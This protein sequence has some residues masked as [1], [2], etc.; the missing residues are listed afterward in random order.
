MERYGRRTEKLIKCDDCCREEVV[1]EANSSRFA[2]LNRRY[3]GIPLSG[4]ALCY[5]LLFALCLLFPY[6]GDDWTWGSYIGIDRLSSGFAD[7]NGR[8]AGNVVVIA[9]TRNYFVRSLV[10]A[11][12]LLAVPVLVTKIVKGRLSIFI[13]SMA[14]VA[15]MP[16]AVRAQGIV[17]TSGFANYATS[18]I[19][20]L[21]YLYAFRK[22]F[23]GV[24]EIRGNWVVP[25]FAFG[26]VGCLFVENVSIY[27]LLVSFLM[28]MFARI[29]CGKWDWLQVAFFIGALVGCVLMFSNGNYGI[30]LSGGDDLRKVE[31]GSL[32]ISAASHYLSGLFNYLCLENGVL[33]IVL[34]V[35]VAFYYVKVAKFRVSNLERVIWIAVL[36]YCFAFAFFSFYLSA[37]SDS[38]TPDSGGVRRATA[39]L[40]Y[41]IALLL[42]VFLAARV[43]HTLFPVFV[44]LSVFALFLPF[45]LIEPVGPRNFLTIYVAYMVLASW[46]M[47]RGFE[48]VKLEGHSWCKVMR[49]ALV[50]GIA[51]IVLVLYS[52]WYVTYWEVFAIESERAAA[53]EKGL[54]QDAASITIAPQP[55]LNN[56]DSVDSPVWHGNPVDNTWWNTVYKLYYGIPESVVLKVEEAS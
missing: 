44:I 36:A 50:G 17:W 30:V 45:L 9:L 51:V 8:Y 33:N 19:C 49:T 7:Y 31:E 42:L 52:P 12:F 18:T 34:A 26:V 25:A 20:F 5:F 37:I 32:L 56:F 43:S 54:F 46:F 47:V 4:F 11:A 28:V 14:L 6:S 24:V 2:F 13:L 15:A 39:S 1:G 53:V 23:E 22:R 29:K 38:Y 48:K 40:V 16:V 10:M 3:F 27:F 41:L 21:V 35:S 55:F